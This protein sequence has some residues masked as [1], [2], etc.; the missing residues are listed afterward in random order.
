MWQNP[1]G[2]YLPYKGVAGFGQVEFSEPMG[3]V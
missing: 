3:K 1:T 2:F